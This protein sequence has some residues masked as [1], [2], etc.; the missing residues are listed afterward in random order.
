MRNVFMSFYDNFNLPTTTE[1]CCYQ[2]E[3][4]FICAV[5]VPLYK[6]L[7]KHFYAKIFWTVLKSLNLIEMC[8]RPSTG[9][10]KSQL[11]RFYLSRKNLSTELSTMEVMVG[12]LDM[13]HH[14]RFLYRIMGQ[15]ISINACFCCSRNHNKY[16][17]RVQRKGTYESVDDNKCVT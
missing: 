8:L 15:K 9:V 2:V 7:M 1:S 10:K 17:D 11:K 12:N 5:S 14:R 6:K 3:G 13:K 4:I 16:R